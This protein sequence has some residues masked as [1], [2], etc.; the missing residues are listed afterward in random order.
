MIKL[1]INFG[2]G[3][4]RN[5]QSFIYRQ[6]PVPGIH[7]RKQFC[8]FRTIPTTKEKR[9]YYA[10]EYECKEEGIKFR[11]RRSA[12]TLPDAYDDIYRSD[13]RSKS[14]KKMKKSNQWM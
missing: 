9:L 7:H 12:R 5:E 11:G 2:W 8:S 4:R 1:W 10:Y 13:M 6:T 14:W 3:R